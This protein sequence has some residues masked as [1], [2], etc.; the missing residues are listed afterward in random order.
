MTD[1]QT[2]TI[3]VPR[4]YEMMLART[5]VL[6]KALIAAADCIDELARTAINAAATTNKLCAIWDGL[7]ELE[8]E[9]LE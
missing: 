6:S 4:S 7:E 5:N 9:E 8:N 1:K 3:Y 2:P